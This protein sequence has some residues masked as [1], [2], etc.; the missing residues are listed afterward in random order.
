[1]SEGTSLAPVFR[2]VDHPR[3]VFHFTPTSASWL[4][5][6]ENFFSALTRRRLKRGVFKSI[7]D[8]QAAIKRYL[9]EHNADPKPFVWPKPA[10]VILAK[11]GRLPVPPRFGAQAPPKA[12]AADCLNQPIPTIPGRAWFTYL[13]LFGPLESYFNRSWPMPDIEPVVL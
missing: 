4:N 1:M 2:H 3:W 7:V 8:L 6:V 11:V 13:R 9:D 12:K 5:A 10:D